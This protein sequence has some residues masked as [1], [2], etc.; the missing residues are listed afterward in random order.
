MK[1]SN[2][3]EW[4]ELN[5]DIA[6]VG[7]TNFGR[8]HLGEVVNIELPVVGKQVNKDQE[9]GVLESNKA[10]VDFHSP[11]SGEVIQVNEKLK[12]DLKILNESPEKE[13]WIFKLKIKNPKE[14]ESLMSLEEYEKKISQ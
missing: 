4:V 11:L 13:G 14:F 7:V 10:A 5:K 8:M 9:I 12:K 3:H 1:F 6:T 2:T